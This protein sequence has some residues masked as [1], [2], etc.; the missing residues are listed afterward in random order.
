MAFKI[1]GSIAFKNGFLECNPVLL[2][3]IY[4]LEIIVP[5]ANTGDV[6]GD[7]S[8]RRGKIMGMEPAGKYQRI[9]AQAPLAELFKYST[10]LRSMTG[11]RGRH[12]QKFSHYEPVPREYAEKVMAAYQATR[13]GGEE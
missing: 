8:S 12:S 1:A 6:M 7:M 2:E 10:S 5:D 3:P 11:G 4:D 9:K 13:K